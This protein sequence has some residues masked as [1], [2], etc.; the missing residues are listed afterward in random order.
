MRDQWPVGGT[1]SSI[2]A[3]N[4]KSPFQRVIQI[5]RFRGFAKGGIR[6]QR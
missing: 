5:A 1:V 4:T 3:E 6:M 2:E